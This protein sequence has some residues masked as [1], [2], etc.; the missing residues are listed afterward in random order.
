LGEIFAYEFMRRALIAS[1]IVGS[2]CALVGVFVIL[3]GLSFMGAGI[4]HSAFAGV[5]LGLLTGIN[6]YIFSIIF[7][8]TSAIIIGIVGEKG[9]FKLDI[10]IGII[11]SFTMALAILFIGLLNK[12]DSRVM[13]YLFGDIL[14]VKWVDII[15]VGIVTVVS[16]LFF[17][18][19]YKEIKFVIFDKEL[20][21]ISGIP[22][23]FI[24]YGF[25]IL[26]ALTVVTSMKAVGVIL[27]F[28]QI[29]TPAAA[30]YQ[31]T[32]KFW[33]IVVLSVIFG[34]LSSFIGLIASYYLNIPSGASIVI[35]VTS[36]FIL[37]IIFSPK[38]K[39]IK[40]KGE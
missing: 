23:N 3:K 27:V 21:S 30:A 28:A 2:L 37:S 5:T 9:K 22:A 1:F 35:T 11:F 31:L 24:F 17:F 38:R 13:S 36:I 32:H 19:F 40:I 25:L 26:I 39:R 8:V 6:P 16:I 14:S 29:V 18:L 33:Q 4:A 20:A 10:P 15:I 34:I 12:Y 7:G